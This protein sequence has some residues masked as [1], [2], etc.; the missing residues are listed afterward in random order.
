MQS[1]ATRPTSSAMTRRWSDPV[2]LSNRP[3][4]WPGLTLKHRTPKNFEEISLS[5]GFVTYEFDSM[6]C[7]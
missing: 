2:S 3:E 4:R 6:F 1:S 5:V 7:Y